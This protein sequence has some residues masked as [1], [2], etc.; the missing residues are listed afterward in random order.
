MLSCDK[1][2]CALAKKCESK[3]SGASLVSTCL[4]A[5]SHALECAVHDF[6]THEEEDH[7]EQDED[8]YHHQSIL[9][10]LVAKG[11]FEHGLN[12][13]LDDVKNDDDET[14]SHC[15]SKGKEEEI[16]NEEANKMDKDE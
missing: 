1:L 6:E 2:V 12:D 16:E 8:C 11:D 13:V 15:D 9:N 4:L 5:S 14:T 3:I 10:C 7:E